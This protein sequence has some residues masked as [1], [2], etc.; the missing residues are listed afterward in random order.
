MNDRVLILDDVIPQAYADAV[1]NFIFK[2]NIYKLKT[3]NK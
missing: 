3:Y 2:L 1:E